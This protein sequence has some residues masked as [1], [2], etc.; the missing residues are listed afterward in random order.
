[1][2]PLSIRTT[3]ST[4]S[5]CI[6]TP[7]TFASFLW[8]PRGAGWSRGSVRLSKGPV[9]LTLSSEG[10]CHSKVDSQMASRSKHCLYFILQLAHFGHLFTSEQTVAGEVRNTPTGLSQFRP[11]PPVR[12][13][14]G[15]PWSRVAWEWTD[16]KASIW[17]R[18]EID[19]GWTFTN[20]YHC[21]EW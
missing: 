10:Q 5:F 4:Q 19:A 9:S 2:L 6:I 17:V 11:T 7:V 8:Q 13:G 1:M 14:I 3:P 18:R 12:S 21:F 15:F 20:V 16:V